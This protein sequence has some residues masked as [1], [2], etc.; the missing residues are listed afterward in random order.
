V[1]QVTQRDGAG[2]GIG[3]GI[4]GECDVAVIGA[5]PA[6]AVAAL[7]VLQSWPDA[8]VRLLDR[9][10][11]PR[12]KTCGDGLAAQTLDVLAEVGE[13]TL[14]DD[15]PRVHRLRLGFPDGT[16]VARTMARPTLVVP[17]EVLDARLVEA[18]VKRGA[19]LSRH[20]VRQVRPEGSGAVVDGALRARVVIGAD[21]AHSAVRAGLGLPAPRPGTTA[22]ALRGYAPVPAARAQEQVIAFAGHAAWPA[23]AW[24]FPVGDGRANVGYGEAL[25]VD[26]PGPSRARMLARLEA[27]LPGATDGVQGLKAHHLPLSTGRVRQPDGPVLLTGDALGLVNPLTG[28]G[29]HAAMR[30]GAVAGGV[31]ARVARAGAGE[32]AGS[33]YRRRLAAA[34]GA[35]LRH[36]DLV[37]RL[38]VDPRV[39]RAGLEVSAK[40]QR[41]FDTLVELGLADGTLTPQLVF[42]LIRRAGAGGL[43]ETLRSVRRRDRQS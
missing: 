4:G 37:I 12:D 35:H 21:G 43:V 13:P 11:F 17:R 30:S 42:A 25:P 22:I 8:R 2:D 9:A 36:M 27:L 19:V 29:I 32:R 5:G 33:R 26:G 6:G 40:D 41:V 10:D 31:A 24:S 3:I 7:A 20:R 1:A 38:S 15:W 16:G 23:Y 28:E 18:V 34:M 39:V 14:L